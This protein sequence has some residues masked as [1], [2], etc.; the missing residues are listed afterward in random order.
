MPREDPSVLWP[1]RVTAELIACA[2]VQLAF[3][4]LWLAVGGHPGSTLM[5]LLGTSAFAMG[6]QTAAAVTLGST[7]S[8]PPP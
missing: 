1:A 2:L 5:I 4:V 7:P 3:W 6:M 8:S